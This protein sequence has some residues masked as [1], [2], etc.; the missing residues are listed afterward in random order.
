MKNLFNTILTNL[1]LALM[2]ALT[3]TV[4][5]I[6]QGPP[7]GPPPDPDHHAGGKVTAVSSTSI[8]V[9]NREGETQIIGVTAVTKF[10]R[11]GEAASLSAFQVNDFVRA[12]GAKNSSG[13][14]VAER[15]MGGDRPPQGPGGQGGPGGRGPRGPRDGVF[16]EYVS[17]NAS[18]G[19][20]T[21]KTPDG[22]ET[23]VYT[24]STTDISRNRQAASLSDFKAGDHV[25]AM[26]KAD[27]DGK[28]MATRIMGGDQP[29]PRRN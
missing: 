16:G 17:A 29:P 25:G 20:L 22:K 28:Y 24:N 1:L 6:A 26:G 10:V 23:T 2:V 12:S 11:N 14:F 15:V 5:S 7:Q 3:A 9:A 27:S 21:I 13:Q 8:T 18:A 19:T 4:T